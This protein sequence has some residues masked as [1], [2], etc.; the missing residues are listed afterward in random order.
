M[1]AIIDDWNK[2][3]SKQLTPSEFANTHWE[4]FKKIYNSIYHQLDMSD[5]YLTLVDCVTSLSKRDVI[6]VF[7]FDGQLFQYYKIVLKNKKLAKAMNE[8]ETQ[9]IQDM[10]ENHGKDVEYTE[11]NFNNIEDENDL[12]ILLNDCSYYLSK[13]QMEAVILLVRGYTRNEV[14]NILGISLQALNNR[15]WQCRDIIKDICGTN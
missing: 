5:L 1:S 2:I 9:S 6:P 15:V 12:D 11:H 4:E 8:P 7:N 14:A 13:S 10:L 3:V